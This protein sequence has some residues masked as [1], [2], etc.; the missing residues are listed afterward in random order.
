[1][2]I[3]KAKSKLEKIENPTEDIKDV[4]DDLGF[5]IADLN[6]AKYKLFQ[7]EQDELIINVKKLFISSI[8]CLQFNIQ[9][10]SGI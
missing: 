5:K 8:L 9:I 3:E 6:H 7:H 1:M 4:I 2:G 10:L